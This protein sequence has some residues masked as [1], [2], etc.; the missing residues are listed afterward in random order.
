MGNLFSTNQ[1]LGLSAGSASNLLPTFLEAIPMLSSILSSA[2]GESSGGLLSSLRALKEDPQA[3]GRLIQ[4]LT[5]A[6]PELEGL[7]KAKE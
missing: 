7:L 6:M 1:G 4:Q 5:G 3:L 2:G